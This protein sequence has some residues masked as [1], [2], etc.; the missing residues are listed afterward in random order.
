MYPCNKP[1]KI[2]Y[3]GYAHCHQRGPHG[4]PVGGPPLL[5]NVILHGFIPLDLS[6]INPAPSTHNL[7]LFSKLP[8][9]LF[10]LHI[11]KEFDLLSLIRFRSTSRHTHYVVDTIPEFQLLVK[12]APQVIRGV[13][14]VQ[15]NV[16]ASVATIVDK[17]RQRNCDRCNNI[18]HQIW[19]PTLDRLCFHCAHRGPMPLEEEEM[20]KHYSLTKNDLHLIPSFRFLPVTL[21]GP[22]IRESRPLLP[23]PDRPSGSDLPWK[24]PDFDPRL[25]RPKPFSNS[26][27]VPQQHILYDT[28]VAAQ[29]ALERTGQEIL[30]PTMTEDKE[31]Q[32]IVD[33]CRKRQDCI[34]LPPSLVPRRCRRAM[35][36]VF[37]PWINIDGAEAGVFCQECL[38]ITG[39][40][41]NHGWGYPNVEKDCI[42]CSQQLK[43]DWRDRRACSYSLHLPYGSDVHTIGPYDD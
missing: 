21:Q 20:L 31:V 18:A 1:A 2:H 41:M 5:T 14:A 36:L 16:V 29:L 38:Y 19:L 43:E 13:L 28:Q 8:D 9:E 3:Y 15:A 25:M 40:D 6:P 33:D 10:Y 37:A 22:Q 4:A 27:R 42:S 39:K 32:R 30:P 7:G 23:K 17:L 35:G 12:W 34:D 11:I 24:V 26:F